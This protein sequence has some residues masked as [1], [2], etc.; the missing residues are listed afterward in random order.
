MTGQ[1]SALVK[2]FAPEPLR[3]AL[4]R[5]RRV[6]RAVVATLGTPLR[7]RAY[8]SPNARW[9]RSLPTP[10]R[11]RWRLETP[12]PGS[13]R[14]EVGS[15]WNPQ[16]GY[17]HVDLDPD[18]SKV[19]LLVPGH[20]L[21]FQ[22]GWADELLSVHMIEHVPPPVLRGM[23]REWFRV[24]RDGGSLHIH[25][26]NGESL[27]RALI[28][29]LSEAGNSFWPIQ[30]AI[31]GYGMAPQQVTGPERLTNPADHSMLFTF[32]VLRSLLEEAGFS[33]IENVSGED[34]CYHSPY[35]EPYIP[36]LCLEVRAFKAGTV[37]NSAV[38]PHV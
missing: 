38:E 36:G 13:R 33:R 22:D 32:P 3:P 34:P 1:L 15:G 16:P 9:L 21:P 27:A 31:Y 30:A 12:S 6:G 18:S 14:I 29:S 19:D 25:T 26:P 8:R 7:V 37:S 23:L 2:R 5:A 24:V 11:R 35:W 17:I 28:D 10:L 4:R 20:T